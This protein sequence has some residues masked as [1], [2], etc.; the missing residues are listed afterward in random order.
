MRSPTYDRFRVRSP[1]GQWTAIEGVHLP[2][3]GI[4]WEA[5]WSSTAT[6]VT[7]A[8]MRR[9]EGREEYSVV[10]RLDRRSCKIETLPEIERVEAI[11]ASERVFAWAPHHDWAIMTRPFLG[12][13]P[14]TRFE[15]PSSATRLSYFGDD[16]VIVLETGFAVVHQG[17]LDIR[18]D[19]VRFIQ[20]W[21]AA[22]SCWYGLVSGVARSLGSRV[23]RVGA[24]LC[25]IRGDAIE[26]IWAEVPPPIDQVFTIGAAMSFP[27][28]AS[29]V[30][31]RMA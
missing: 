19:R 20:V 14:V 25:R 12:N 11:A 2:N 29:I 26:P 23:E 1:S 9:P 13:E 3:K 31:I 17:R 6:H 5:L 18:H 24:C 15:L 28:A 22:G 8:Q 10:E 27:P 4:G 7:Y 16:L 30:W 21:P